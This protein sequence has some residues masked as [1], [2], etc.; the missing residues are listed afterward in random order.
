[1]S[2]P[3]E[4]T[5]KDQA[6]EWLASCGFIFPTNEKELQRFH[7]LHGKDNT[8]IT[9]KEVDPFRI[10]ERAKGAQRK[11]IHRVTPVKPMYDS[12]GS[13]MVA[14]IKKSTKKDK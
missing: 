3:E 13:Q 8:S 14:R 7:A 5:I 1:M 9:G 10:I 2:V 4:N 11:V 12:R 6:A